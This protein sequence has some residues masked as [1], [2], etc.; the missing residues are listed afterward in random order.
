MTGVNER[1]HEI[2]ARL[3][4][5]V[6]EVLRFLDSPTGRRLRRVVATGLILSLPL[7]MRIPGLRRSFV[8]R[9]IEVAGGTTLVVKLAE[10]IRDWERGERPAPTVA[11]PPPA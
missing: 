11:E 7:V 5:P 3:G 10:L 6:E 9:A 8:G 1:L 4:A 2:A